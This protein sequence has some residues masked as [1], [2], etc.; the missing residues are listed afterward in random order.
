MTTA[1]GCAFAALICFGVGDW[2]YRRAARDGVAAHHFLM[3]QAWLFCPFVIL[4]AAAT[5]TLTVGGA[6]LWGNLAGLFLFVGFLL[7]ARSLRTGPVS[8]NGPIF[9][10][11]FV[12]TVV[13]AIAFLGEPLTAAKAGGLA[14]A[15]VAVPLLLGAAPASNGGRR[16]AGRSLAEVLVATVAAGAG[17]F[18]HKLG[19]LGGA[20]PASLVAAQA[21]VFASLATLSTA[22]VERSLR[23]PPG[24]W[25]HAVPAAVVLSAAFLF[26]VHALAAGQASVVVP[27]AQMGFVPAALL[28]IG[29]GGEAM[30]ARK[31]LGLA[32][33]L[34]ALAL[35]AL[36]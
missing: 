36:A 11:G 33:A 10:L 22:T 14:L 5:G 19:S 29:F 32:A 7:F 20:P 34:A 27:I 17:Y 28:G 18:C 24:L 9:R 2:I 3:G 25:R 8:V 30:T 16:L 31:G 26:F 23:W 13:L 4:F 35:L 15:L 21:M 6:A 1:T 12:V